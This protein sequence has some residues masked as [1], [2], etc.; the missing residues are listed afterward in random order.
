[1]RKKN[2]EKRKT[3]TLKPHLAQVLNEMGEDSG[4]AAAA[5]A[6]VQPFALS[7]SISTHVYTKVGGG[8]LGGVISFSPAE[9]DE[10]RGWGVCLLMEYAANEGESWQ[11]Q[12][13]YHLWL[14]SARPGSTRPGPATSTRSYKLH[15]QR[16]RIRCIWKHLAA[17]ALSFDTR[18]LRRGRD[19]G[20]PR[21]HKHS[22]AVECGSLTH[23]KSLRR[24]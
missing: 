14:G 15:A 11:S 20:A 3:T 19:H 23:I 24:D 6:C 2:N 18:L 9:R 12:R 7:C 17:I 1:M 8:G 13:R 21:Q 4:S 16:K 22:Q 10:K 5:S